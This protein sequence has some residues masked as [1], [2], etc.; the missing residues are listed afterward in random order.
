MYHFVKNARQS[1]YTRIKGL[2]KEEFEAQLHYLNKYYNFVKIEDCINAVHSKT[3]SL[4][5]NSVLLTFDDGYI[6][7]FTTVFPI[8]MK[9]NIQGSF[10]PPAR[11]ITE[12]KVLDVNKIHFVLASVKDIKILLNDVFGLIDKYR[13]TF[14]LESNEYYYSRLSSGRRYDSKDVT[15]IKL[16]LQQGLDKTLIKL[17]LGELFGKYVTNDEA[18]FSNE[19]YMSTDQLKCMIK[20]GMYVGCHGNS[21]AKLDILSPEDQEKD[22]D[23]A[24]DFMKGI[25][26]V[27][28]NWVMSYPY[29]AYDDNLINLL[30]RKKCKLGLSTNVGI[31]ELESKNAFTLQRL[32]T[33]DLPKQVNSGIRPWTNIVMSDFPK[34]HDRTNRNEHRA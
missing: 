7:H 21:H 3:S 18:A 8:L 15:F 26:S 23:V 32:D 25:G 1:R 17:I 5:P 6:D 11:A 14:N 24:L 2:L 30:Q 33:N 19:L 20:S 31:A 9:N 13:N 29:G 27:T 4:P 28:E 10:F 12:N 34:Y 16:L 22:I